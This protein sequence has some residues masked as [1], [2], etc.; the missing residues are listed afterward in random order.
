MLTEYAV[1]CAM[2]NIPAPVELR[3]VTGPNE[4]SV[5]QLTKPS[6]VFGD[7]ELIG[8]SGEIP[9]SR[10]AAKVKI[11]NVDPACIPMV[12]LYERSTL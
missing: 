11:L 7:G 4:A 9:D 5:S 3:T 10:A 6:K 12:P 1:P 2:P 8:S